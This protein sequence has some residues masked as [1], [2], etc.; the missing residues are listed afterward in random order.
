MEQWIVIYSFSAKPLR[1]YPESYDKKN[2]AGLLARPVLKP[3]HPPVGEQWQ[4]CFQNIPL[5]VGKGLT[6][7]GTAPESPDSYRG[8]RIPFSFRN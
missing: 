4:E 7:A 6:A 1:F 5:K 2:K 3:S 8:H